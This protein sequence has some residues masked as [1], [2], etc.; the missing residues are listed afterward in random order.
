MFRIS[1]SRPHN[2]NVYE[3]NKHLI[4][5][6]LDADRLFIPKGNHKS[7]NHTHLPMHIHKLIHNRQQNRSNPQIITFN[8]HINKQI[9]YMN[10]KQTPRNN[11]LTKLITNKTEVFA[12]ELKQPLLT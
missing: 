10:T 2:E 5:A 7:T 8:N 3:A 6:T 4:K 11:I 12:S 1:F 9:Q